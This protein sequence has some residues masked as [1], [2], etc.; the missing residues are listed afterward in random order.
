MSFYI[1]DGKDQNVIGP[2]DAF[3]VLQY[4]EGQDLKNGNWQICD[5]SHVWKP[6]ADQIASLAT[7]KRTTSDVRHIIEG[8]E[9]GAEKD[10]PK[11][12]IQGFEDKIDL[13]ASI[14]RLGKVRQVFDAIWAKQR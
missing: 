3:E 8:T 6:L 7:A 9:T 11:T 13:A 4:I 14:E 12:N 1:S 5:Q 2:L 10:K